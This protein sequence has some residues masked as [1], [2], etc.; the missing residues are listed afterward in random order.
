MHS[1][2]R[3]TVRACPFTSFSVPQNPELHNHGVASE[4]SGGLRSKDYRI[5]LR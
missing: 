2:V 4:I 5:L 1:P 3:F